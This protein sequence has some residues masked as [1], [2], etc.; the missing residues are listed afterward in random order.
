VCLGFKVLLKKSHSLY[1]KWDSSM[2]WLSGLISILS[3][4]ITS[5]AKKKNWNP[6]WYIKWIGDWQ[7]VS[8][9]VFRP[10]NPPSLFCGNPSPLNTALLGSERIGTLSSTPST[11]G[12]FP[13]LYQE[14]ATRRQSYYFS[15]HNAGLKRVWSYETFIVIKTWEGLNKL[16]TKY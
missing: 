3:L 4:F 8:A 7:P 13:R 5:Y 9:L 11:V 10:E 16:M 12:C 6:D 15:T 14:L 1:I 2:R